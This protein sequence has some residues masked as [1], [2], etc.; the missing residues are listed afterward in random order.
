VRIEHACIRGT[1]LEVLLTILFASTLVMAFAT[2][3]ARLTAQWHGGPG[4]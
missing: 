3:V 1:I 2:V 4:G